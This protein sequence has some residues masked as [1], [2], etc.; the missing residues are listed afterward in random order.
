LNALSL[1]D[2]PSRVRLLTAGLPGVGGRIRAV[3]ED[4]VVEEI[5]LYAALG[6]GPH[7]LF[8]LEKRGISTFEATMWLSRLAKVSERT[9][10]YAGLKDAHAVTRQTMS[11]HRVSPER[12]LAIEHH[13]IRVLSAA[14]H[15]T[16]VRIG[17]LRGNRFTIRIREAR[18]DRLDAAREALATIVARGLP[19]AYGSQRFGV[20]QDGHLLGRAVVRAD[21][22]EFLSHLLGRPHRREGDPRVR[23][24]RE[25][26][27]RGE[28]EE[29]FRLFPG[30]HR[31]QKLALGE[32]L[33]SGDAARAFMALGKR[34]RRIYVSAYQSWLFNQCLDARMAAGTH[35]R[36][37]AGDVAWQHASGALYRVTDA[38]AEAP[39]AER[40]EA[41]PSGPLPGY[42]L[43]AAEGDALAIER[44]IL[45]AEDLRDELFQSP[46]VR[47]RGARRPYRVPVADASLDI[48][49]ETTVVA[50]FTLPPGSFA[51]VL[52]R[53][54]M[55]NEGGSSSG[56]ADEAPGTDGESDAGTPDAADSIEADDVAV[57][58]DESGP[59]VEETGA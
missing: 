14:R 45:D 8:E 28:S 10:G 20:K 32:L 37:L 31:I 18:V 51:T 49:D 3:P 9:I 17:H 30:K 52:L 23:K 59:S 6:E 38:A 50:R 39:R 16:R 11:A 42:G 34:P 29:A 19:N 53:E 41:S 48:E 40:L 44:R 55:K 22:R 13:K 1:V 54:L 33:R 58:D 4:F 43:R 15:P 46:E 27:D 12:L 2:G 21:F 26:Y 36:L 47:T 7:V 56:G 35:D 5:P 57:G 24:A 25:A